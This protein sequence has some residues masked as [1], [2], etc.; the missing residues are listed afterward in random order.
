MQT[1]TAKSMLRNRIAT[2]MPIEQRLA[3]CQPHRGLGQG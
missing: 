3:G 1:Q 2:Q